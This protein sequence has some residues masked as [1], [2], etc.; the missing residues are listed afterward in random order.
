LFRQEDN[1][2]L[3][4]ADLFEKLVRANHGAGGFGQLSPL[5]LFGIQCNA[6]IVTEAIA[7][8][9]LCGAA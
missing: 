2:D 8:R 1:G 4:L 6:L 7:D 5:R 9:N 3:A